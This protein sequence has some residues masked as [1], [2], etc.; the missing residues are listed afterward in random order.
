MQSQSEVRAMSVSPSIGSDTT[1]APSGLHRAVVIVTQIH[2]LYSG[3]PVYAWLSLNQQGHL[4]LF[5][6]QGG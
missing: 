1:T 6:L 3:P 2:T 5:L 4:S